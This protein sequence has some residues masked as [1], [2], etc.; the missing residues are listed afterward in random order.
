MNRFKIHSSSGTILL[1]NITVVNTN[2]TTSLIPYN[3][4]YRQE[5]Y[6][7]ELPPQRVDKCADSSLII[8]ANDN[9]M[10]GEMNVLAIP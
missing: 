7:G 8:F 2:R 5:M 9:E 4:A 3:N 6:I 10:G 1:L